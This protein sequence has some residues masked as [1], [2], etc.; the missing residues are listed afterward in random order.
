MRRKCK[1]GATQIRITGDGEY[2][3]K[4]RKP[5]WSCISK[6]CPHTKRAKL[7]FK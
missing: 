2:L 7:Q 6:T 3:K 4:L 5:V 1:C